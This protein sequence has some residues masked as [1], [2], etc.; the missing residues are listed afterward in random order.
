MQST[1]LCLQVVYWE[2]LEK[3]YAAEVSQ[4]QE[5]FGGEQGEHR[6]KDFKLVTALCGRPSLYD[7][8]CT[9]SSMF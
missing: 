3:K 6:H 8:P 2:V 1:S 9:E 5:V 4:Q 7:M